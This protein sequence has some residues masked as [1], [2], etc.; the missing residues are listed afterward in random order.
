M[1]AKRHG[2]KQISIAEKQRLFWRHNDA[3][4]SPL[5]SCGTITINNL[6]TNSHDVHILP[7]LYLE[8]ISQDLIA[9]I[10]PFCI[11][12]DLSGVF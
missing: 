12:E 11:N 1:L 7:Q 8:M 9:V 4:I 6:R 3:E 10:E 5:Q 2:V